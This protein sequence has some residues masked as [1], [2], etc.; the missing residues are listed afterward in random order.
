MFEVPSKDVPLIV[1]AVARAVAVDAFPTKAAV[2]WLKTT[3]DEVPTAW[4]IEKVTPLPDAA[5]VTPVPPNSD[6]VSESRSIAI[7]EDPSVISKS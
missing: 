1:L 6:K 4:P 2:T 7:V 5:A 3:F